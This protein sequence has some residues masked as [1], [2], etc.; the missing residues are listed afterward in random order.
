MHPPLARADIGSRRSHMNQVVPSPQPMSR[1]IYC[2]IDGYKR[3]KL[4]LM[5][6]P[7]TVEGVCSIHSARTRRSLMQKLITAILLMGAL[8][9][10]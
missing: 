2:S 10:F 9:A 3:S 8:L 7:G 6:R 5:H 1:V 4:R